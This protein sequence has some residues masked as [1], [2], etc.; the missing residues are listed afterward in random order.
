MSQLDLANR[1]CRPCE[2][3]EPPLKGKA[4]EELSEQLGEGWKVVEEDHLKKEYD[5]ND[6]REALVFTNAVGNIAEREDH[7]PDMELGW[8]RVQ[9]SLKTHKIDGLSENDFI[10]AAKADRAFSEMNPG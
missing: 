1:S 4:L 9:I 5:F 3:D 8:G 7:H 10:L 6:F 2:G